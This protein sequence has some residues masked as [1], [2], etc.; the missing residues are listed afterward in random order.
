MEADFWLEKWASNEIGFH[1]DQPHPCLALC[2][3]GARERGA[4]RVFVPLCGKSL[5]MVALRDAGFDV[6]GVELSQQALRDFGDEQGLSLTERRD[7]GLNV[8]EAP[9]YTL[10]QG[11]FFALTAAQMAGVDA[12]YDRG[13]LVALPPSMRTDYVQ[14]LLEL[15]PEA[16]SLTVTLEYDQREMDGPPFSVDSDLLQALYASSRVIEQ[17]QCTDILEAEPHFIEKGLTGLR[18]S[19]YGLSPPA[20]SPGREQAGA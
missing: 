14:R 4:R 15:C 3:A 8:F 17:L 16:W 19:A 9:G 11:D 5:D 12:I 1:R 6:V 20:P 2:I 10:Y 13:A 18:E 7:A